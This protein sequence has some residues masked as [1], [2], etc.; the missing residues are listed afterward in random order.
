LSAGA[1]FDDFDL[2]DLDAG[3]SDAA[4][5]TR[6]ALVDT[7]EQMGM[8]LDIM[9]IGLLVHTS[10]AILFANRAACKLL[11]IEQ[12][13]AVG[14]HVLDFMPDALP[15]GLDKAINSAFGGSDPVEFETM[16]RSVKGTERSVRFVVGALPWQ[17]TP[18]IQILMQDITEQKRADQALRRLSITDELTGAF[19]RR[20]ALYEAGLYIDPDRGDAPGLS[21]LLLDID[22]FKRVNDRYG[23]PAGD[24]ALRQVARVATKALKDVRPDDASIFARFGGEE[25]LV[26]LPGVGSSDAARVAEHLRQAIAG[27]RVEVPGGSAGLPASF[28]LSASFGCGTYAPGDGGIDGLLARVDKA[29]YRSKEDGR[30]RVTLA[31]PPAG[32]LHAV[33]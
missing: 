4:E 33:A 30:D 13:A 20:H 29:L 7:R 9:P 8:M 26:L 19:N 11:D 2:F 18:V 1:L 31:A 15:L 32:C 24:E 16:V 3:A 6:K 27:I 12:E 10:Q 22:H 25:F 14:N 17:G 5:Q 28:G 23:H 21:V